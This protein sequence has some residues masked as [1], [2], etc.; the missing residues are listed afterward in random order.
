MQILMK[1][2]SGKNWLEKLEKLW[3][4]KFD[5]PRRKYFEYF[6]SKTTTTALSGLN[7]VRRFVYKVP[8]N[9]HFLR[10]WR[11]LPRHM[12]ITL[13][14]VVPIAI[15]VLIVPSGETHAAGGILDSLFGISGILYGAIASTM[16]GIAWFISMIAGIII[17]VLAWIIEV[18]LNMSTQVVNSSPVKTGFPITLAVTNMG[19]VAAVIIIAIA[20]IIRYG[21]YAVKKTLP[22]LI[23]AALLVNFSL[24][25]A[26]AILNFAD[27]F[28]LYFVREI[29]PIQGQ[30]NSIGSFASAMAGAF[31]PQREF[32][33]KSSDPKESGAQEIAGVTKSLGAE[34]GKYLVPMISVS[35]TLF[36]LIAIV[37][38]LV[39]FVALLLIR[40][41]YLV[42]LLIVMPFVW[43]MWIFPDTKSYFS[44]WWK[45]FLRQV[46]FAPVVVFF[47]YLAILYAGS[48]G[49]K[50]VATD[51]ARARETLG[52]INQ[53]S[54]NLLGTPIQNLMN[55]LVII[56]LM[57]G[58]MFA[59]NKIG[60]AGASAAQK[61][62]MAGTGAIGMGMHTRAGGK[63]AR[64]M[65]TGS[66]PGEKAPE[67]PRPFSDKGIW[68]KIA[69]PFK[70]ASYGA[71]KAA[72]TSGEKVS[73]KIEKK[74]PKLWTWA[75]AKG[76]GELRA[77]A[78]AKQPMGF[79]S[80]LGKET[81]GKVFFKTIFDEAGIENEKARDIFGVGKHKH[82]MTKKEFEEFTGMHFEDEHKPEAPS[83]PAGG[84]S[85]G[86]GPAPAA[87]P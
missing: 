31:N 37:L 45:K 68:G 21:D 40:Y 72:W 73:E 77:R 55:S 81:F 41:V 58:G 71:K 11:G 49:D 22:K 3:K 80:W 43:L 78:N 57:L 2:F 84:V 25:F 27:Q 16:W 10:G 17:A 47:L 4:G 18:V 13:G 51:T 59:A 6:Y 53:F 67:R 61:A 35:L 20:T 83:A 26:G 7:F 63:V 9:I 8:K 39:A 1:S 33:Q 14:V 86:G 23:A 79:G 42:V 19:F 64:W 66:R 62:V 50:G 85:G 75:G 15:L 76:E 24:V 29:S 65:T 5:F 56:G 52:A 87:H 36:S 69:H 32:I 54:Q 82:K 30:G 46:F 74:A 70:L 38:T 44:D 34:F 60:A 28:T 12:R 48:L